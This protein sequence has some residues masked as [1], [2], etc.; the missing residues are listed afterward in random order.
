MRVAALIENTRI[1]QRRDLHTEPGLALC[2]QMEERQILFDTGVSGTFLSNA[3]R[4]Q[5]DIAQVNLA[6]ISHHHFDHGGGLQTF[7]EVNDHSKIYLKSSCTENFLLDIFGLIRRQ[8]GLDETLFQNYPQRFTFTDRFCE[9]ASNVFIVTE[10]KKLHPLPKGNRHLFMDDG[11]SKQ[12]DDFEHELILVIKRD[13]GLVIFTGCSHHG[14]LNMLDAVVAHFPAQPIKA[15]FGGFH[16]I[17]LP[18]I[19]TMAGSKEDVEELGRAML[20]YPIEKIYTGHCTGQ[21][22]YHIL[23][24]VLG[25]KLEYFATGRQIE[26]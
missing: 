4:L 11:N 20:K 2:I 5:V 18:L 7:L 23:K 22:A 26:V 19:N 17:D 16:L 21:K 12:L 25:T 3:Q 15:L 9:I 10:I 6:V 1:P 8:V 13:T 14:I 24:E